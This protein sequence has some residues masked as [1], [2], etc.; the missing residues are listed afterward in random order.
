MLGV[1]NSS[2]TKR[3][4]IK[5]AKMTL[6]SEDAL[7]ESKDGNE[8]TFTTT[9]TVAPSSPMKEAADLIQMLDITCTEMNNCAADA[10][11]GTR[12]S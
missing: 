4:C 1:L 8:T 12:L 7:A 2:T 5:V 6:Q 10:A 3:A 11:S 9:T